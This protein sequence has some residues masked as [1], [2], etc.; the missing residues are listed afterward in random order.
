[1]L[2]RKNKFGWIVS[3][4]ESDKHIIGLKFNCVFELYC[5]LDISVSLITLFLSDCKLF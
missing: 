1:M 4:F 2:K 3:R 5:F